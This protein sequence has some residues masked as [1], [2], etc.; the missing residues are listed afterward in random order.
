MWK[1][2]H[3]LAADRRGLRYPSDLTDDE[4]AYRG[5]HDPA[6][7]AR[8]AQTVGERARG[9][10]RDH[11]RLEHRMP[12]AGDPERPAA[13]AARCTTISTCGT[14]TAR[15]SASIT[16]F[17]WQCREQEATRSQPDGRDHRLARASKSAEKGGPGSIRMATTRARVR[18]EGACHLWRKIPSRQLSIDLEADERFGWVTG[19]AEAS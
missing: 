7:Q 9:G 3:R 13:D 8:R 17:T 5:A 4:W 1:P 6:G 14:R 12:V 18:L 15:S 10:E 19:R 16:R 11:V 2:E